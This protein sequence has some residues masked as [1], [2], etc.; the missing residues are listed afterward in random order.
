MAGYQSDD[1]PPGGALV[2]EVYAPAGTHEAFVRTYFTAQSLDEM[3][4]LSS[5]APARVPVFVPGCPDFDCPIATFDRIT[6][7]AIDPSFVGD[8]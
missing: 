2:F 7:A 1:T 6:G 8:W 4:T 3:R 5:A